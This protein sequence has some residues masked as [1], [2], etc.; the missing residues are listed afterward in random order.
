MAWMRAVAGRLKSDYSYSNTV[1]YNNFSWPNPTAK[2]KNCIE[3]TAQDILNARANH[4]GASLAALYDRRLMPADLRR[5]HA[6]N[7]KAVMDAYGFPWRTMKEEDCVAELM[8]MYQRL[9]EEGSR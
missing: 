8:R 1:V 4:Q 3:K 6:E 7:D 9:V 2:Q 5:A